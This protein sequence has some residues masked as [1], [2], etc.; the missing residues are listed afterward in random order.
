M[1]SDASSDVKLIFIWNIPL[2]CSKIDFTKFDQWVLPKFLEWTNSKNRFLKE[3]ALFI[4]GDLI[5]KLLS[6]YYKN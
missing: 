5:V 4:I 1:S 6:I 2:L 3:E